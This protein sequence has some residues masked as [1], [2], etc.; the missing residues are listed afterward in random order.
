MTQYLESRE[1][2]I[3]FL[4]QQFNKQLEKNLDTVND[5]Y[6]KLRFYKSNP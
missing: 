3:N 5:A 4:L 2:I 1:S 6:L